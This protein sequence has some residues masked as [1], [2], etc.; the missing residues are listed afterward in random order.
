[1]ESTVKWNHYLPETFSCTPETSLK[2]RSTYDSLCPESP[3]FN[4]GLLGR[5]TTPLSGE[6]WHSST[7]L[8]P[9]SV[10]AVPKE[11]TFPSE[12][13]S[14]NHPAL[15]AAYVMAPEANETLNI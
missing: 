9:S 7:T 10:L 4:V 2:M 11:E 8:V 13:Y 1:M 6:L 5:Q 14:A 3:V 12:L 15:V